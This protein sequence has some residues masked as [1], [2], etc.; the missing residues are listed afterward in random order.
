M[1]AKA[2]VRITTDEGN[3][4]KDIHRIKVKT[5]VSA[6]L[7]I[8]AVF[9]VIFMGFFKVDLGMDDQSY[10]YYQ[11]LPVPVPARGGE[12]YRVVAYTTR[13]E[14]IYNEGNVQGTTN[15]ASVV[16]FDMD[17]GKQAWNFSAP[18][19][20]MNVA[21]VENANEWYGGSDPDPVLLVQF[22]SVAAEETSILIEYSDGPTKIE[23]FRNET[24][25]YRTFTWNLDAPTIEGST[26]DIT[27]TVGN[28]SRA[29]GIIRLPYNATDTAADYVLVTTNRTWQDDHLEI[30]LQAGEEVLFSLHAMRADG[31]LAWTTDTKSNGSPIEDL[32]ATDWRHV[33]GFAVNYTHFVIQ[34][35]DQSIAV[36]S[37]ETGARAWNAS[38]IAGLIEAPHDHSTPADGVPD[39]LCVE[40][41]GNVTCLDGTNGSTV[42]GFAETHL[43][44]ANVQSLRAAS[45]F[46]YPHDLVLVVAHATE[47]VQLFRHDAA[48]FA[49]V[50]EAS[51]AGYEVYQSDDIWQ[52][53][54]DY[55]GRA[56]Q[57]INLGQSGGTGSFI[58]RYYDVETGDTI[59]DLVQRQEGSIVGDFFARWQGLEV[60][61]VESGHGYYV[62]LVLGGTKRMY[63][64]DPVNLAV[65]AAAAVIAIVSAL[66]LVKLRRRQARLSL[67]EE[68]MQTIQVA[69]E[70]SITTTRQTTR[71]LRSLS[72]AMLLVILASTVMFVTMIVVV[73]VG[74]MYYEGQNYYAVRNGYITI[75]LTLVSLPVISVLY[76]YASPGSAMFQIKV[77][78]F[79]YKVL[80]RGRKEHKVLVL[81]MSD[82]AKKF[83]IT[84]II[85][86]SMFPLLV[87]LTLGLTVFGA[88]A[89]DTSGLS[90]T[91]GSINLIWISEF[92]LY[93][94]LA[95]IG[96]Y[97][98]M[99]FISPGG[100]LLDD[101]GVVYFEQPVDAHHP[102]DISKISDWFTGWLKGFFGFTALLNYYTLF[103]GTDLTKL[104]NMSDPISALLLAVF[105]F[106]IMIIASPIIY[107][108]I[109]MFSANASMIDDLEYNRERLYAALKKSGVDVTPR[110]LKDFFDLS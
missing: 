28:G 88:L 56:I 32:N 40:Q 2:V 29:V 93:A 67:K 91:T 71:P 53:F 82:Y 1:P 92:E 63:E 103:A 106:G 96:A 95:F 41:G 47:L 38:S 79:F 100:W 42:T 22:A 51:I 19:P 16:R 73:G 60:L 20:S 105:V 27:G 18:G 90:G 21:Y 48:G 12:P 84:M 4:Y 98:L 45:R 50:W 13:M 62:Y 49:M 77:Q 78:R 39:I 76:N 89:T 31:T 11:N 94:G 64:L 5:A 30:E 104:V 10:T 87:S 74:D 66:A 61:G 80:F 99:A 33:H 108:L 9:I 58:C 7:L 36:A 65:L 14:S 26:T 75:A 83:S 68:E 15:L 8:G 3:I 70:R 81:D 86:R 102:G 59:A 44:D 46:G 72:M 34:R 107:G 54:Y 23:S 101:S 6:S 43:V 17:T 24:G 37:I 69:N 55:E 97:V 52:N 109:A 35:P 25:S 110:R 85:G 57:S